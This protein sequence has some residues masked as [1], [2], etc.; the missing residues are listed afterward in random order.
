MVVNQCG[1]DSHNLVGTDG[2]SDA[3]ATNCDTSVQ[4]TSCHRSGKRHHEI[5]IIVV[6]CERMSPK[7]D[8]LPPRSTKLSNNVLL[9]VKSAVIGCQPYTHDLLLHLAPECC[10]CR[11][12]AVDEQQSVALQPSTSGN[13]RIRLNKS[14][15]RLRLIAASY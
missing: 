9:Q 1:A 4:L 13:R 15:K 11:S 14:G 6:G 8:Y 2:S 5:G 12:F 3:A 10:P 7:V